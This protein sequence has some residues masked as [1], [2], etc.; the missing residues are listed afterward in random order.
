MGGTW[1][2]TNG[3]AAVT[4]GLVSGITSGSDT[5]GY[6][7][8][9]SCGTA[10]AQITV[11]VMAPPAVS[12][13]SG[14]SSVCVSSMMTVSDTNTVGTW[15]SQFPSIATISADGIITGVAAGQDTIMYM[16][17]NACGTAEAF[18]PISVDTL[19]LTNIS[20]INYVCANKTDTLSGMPAGGNWRATNMLATVS[21]GVITGVDP[22]FDTI[23]YSVTN[24]C[25]SDS[26]RMVLPI[27]SKSECDSINL[28]GAVFVQPGTFEI[29]PNPGYSDFSVKITTD[30]QI[31]SVCKV[32]NSI[33]ETVVT[34]EMESN[35]EQF[36]HIPGPAGMY[37]L[38]AQSGAAHYSSRI[39]KL[40]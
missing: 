7:I 35:N 32:I 11:T 15:T 16:A 40:D 20:G 23:Y 31:K 17:A 24:V 39:I 2:A 12:P 19:A 33:G 9:N 14:P 38:S 18:L 25:G 30:N 34:F 5:I 1:F 37:I 8:T 22:G 21:G 4:G 29:V 13:I 10:L 28:V 3:K 36:I 26:S 6:S 27:L